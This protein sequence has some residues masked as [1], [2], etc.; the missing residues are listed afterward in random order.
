[1][2]FVVE[3]SME[4]EEVI[5]VRVAVG[6]YKPEELDFIEGLVDEVFVVGDHLETG[7]FCVYEV[8]GLYYLG[9]DATTHNRHYL[10]TAHQYV[11]DLQLQLLR[12]LVACLLA[13]AHNFDVHSV[14]DDSVVL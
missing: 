8:L 10:V 4:V 13:V 9:K 2:F 12:V 11:S 14:K 6:L 5:R 3:G 7:E 1:M